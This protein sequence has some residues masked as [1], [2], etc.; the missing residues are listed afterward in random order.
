MTVGYVSEHE[1]PR[2]PQRGAA[3]SL[4]PY[5]PTS[6]FTTPFPRRKH[7]I[8]VQSPYKLTL[9]RSGRLDGDTRGNEPKKQGHIGTVRP[10]IGQHWTRGGLLCWGSRRSGIGENMEM[11]DSA[12]GNGFLFLMY[13]WSLI[14]ASTRPGE[15]GTR[16]RS[17][18]SLP[19]TT[20]DTDTAVKFGA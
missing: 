5:L 11:A 4:P 20:P 12:T 14:G 3:F 9:G 1:R 8:K 15:K 7:L 17:L 16:A 18:P 19:P 10:P 13:P 2:D 6:T